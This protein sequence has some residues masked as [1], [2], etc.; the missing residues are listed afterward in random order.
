MQLQ[1]LPHLVHMKGCV[2]MPSTAVP[3]CPFMSSDGQMKP[4]LDNCPLNINGKCSIRIIA[5]NS[6]FRPSDKGNK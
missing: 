3:V 5:E 1:V 4:C 6:E 2:I